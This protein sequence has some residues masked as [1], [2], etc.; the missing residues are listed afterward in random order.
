MGK[1]PAILVLLLPSWLK[2]VVLRAHGARIGQGCRIGF[3][4]IS[5]REIELGDSVYIGHFNLIWRLKRLE[6]GSGS[7]ITLMNWITGAGKGTFRLGA[8]SSVSVQHFLE[9]SGDIEIGA[10]TII[11]GRG[12]QFFTH[13]IAPD[14]LNDI[15]PIRIGDWCYIGSAARFVPGSGCAEGTFLG[16]GAVVCKEMTQEHVLLGGIPAKPIKSLD[17]GAQYFDRPFMP[18]PHHPCGFVPV[19]RD[20]DAPLREISLAS[21]GRWYMYRAIAQL[22]ASAVNGYYIRRNRWRPAAWAE[23]PFFL[24]HIPKAAGSALAKA[25]DLP[26]PGHLLFSDMDQQLRTKLAAKP[27]I[28]VARDP[29]SRVVSTF[30]YIH[31]MQEIRLP[32]LVNC[33]PTNDTIDAFIKRFLSEP[34]YK[35]HYFFKPCHEYIDDARSHGANVTVVHLANLGTEG[36]AF[37]KRCGQPIEVLPQERVS[38]VRKAG[39]DDIGPEAMEILRDF[40]AGDYAMMKA[41]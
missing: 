19:Q 27:C 3:S 12:S 7:R 38:R 33:L 2:I 26:D 37:L 32:D 31:S 29:A 40:Y 1:L 25:A 28:A 15:R 9:A 41:L 14:N 20:P 35:G 24:V 4:L 34:R 16:M 13:G 6:M 17:T 23:A 8:C 30:N 36:P 11:A 10:N 21:R 18:H 39:V 5:A 22:P